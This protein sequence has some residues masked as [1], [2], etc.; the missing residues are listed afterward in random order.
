MN[1]EIFYLIPEEYKGKKLYEFLRAMGFSRQ[2]LTDLKFN[3]PGSYVSINGN[4]VLQNHIL[5]ENDLLKVF[6]VEEESSERIVPV[7]IPIEII[8]EDEDLIVI[9]KTADMPIHPSL[10]NYENSL[11]N[12]LMYYYQKQGKAF[13]HRVINRLDRDTSGLTLVAKNIISANILHEEQKQGILKKEYF[14]IVE[15]KNHDLKESGTIDL[16]IGR[17]DGSTIERVI[18]LNNGE[19]AVTH[20]R[21]I[22]RFDDYCYVNLNLETG[23]THQIRVHMKAIGH[24]LLGDFLYNPS[25][26]TFSRQ[27][28]HVSNLEFIQPITREKI[29]LRAAIPKDLQLFHPRN[30]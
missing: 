10:N 14:A 1:R 6:I 27:A 29:E 26:K 12:A 18:D 4:R 13:T 24:P 5:E 15:D 17:K 11:A 19:R 2:N 30:Q 16:P 3:L 21:V 8:Y 28:L 7:E 20:Y 22:E 23:R 25:D 9:N